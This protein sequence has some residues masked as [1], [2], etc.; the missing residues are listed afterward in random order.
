MSCASVF[1]RVSD[2][3]FV[4]MLLQQFDFLSYVGKMSELNRVAV[5]DLECI[6]IIMLNI[7]IA[8]SRLSINLCILNY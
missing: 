3:D 7:T 8:V 5:Y 4:N 2:Y 1:I 6:N